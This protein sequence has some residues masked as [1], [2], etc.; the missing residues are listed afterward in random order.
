MILLVA[1]EWN[2]IESVFLTQTLLFI[3]QKGVTGS[4]SL[5]CLIFQIFSLVSFL[6]V[7]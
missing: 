6:A 5:G 4:S 2:L 7:A 3:L 1:Q